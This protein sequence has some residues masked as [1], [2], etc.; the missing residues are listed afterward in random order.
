MSQL[1]STFRALLT[2]LAGWPR[3][4]AALICLVLAVLGGLGFGGHAAPAALGSVLVANRELQAG[5]VLAGADLSSARWPATSVPAGALHRSAE[6]VGRR[7]AGALARGEPIQSS[8]LLEPAIALALGSGLVATTIT[9]ADPHQVAI[10]AR[11]SRVDLYGTAS[12]GGSLAPGATEGT[13][14][15][16]NALVLAILPAT[17]LSG[18]LSPPDTPGL[19]IATDHTTAGRLAAHLSA[20]FLA[21]LVPP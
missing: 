4:V 1:S 20:S 13:A 11:G 8:N 10:L 15:A 21:T 17:A 5:V 18:D 19:I 7:V 2:I 16:R 12:P 14:V 9:L 3:R 6:A